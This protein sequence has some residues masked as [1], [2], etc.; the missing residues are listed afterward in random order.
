VADARSGAVTRLDPAVQAVSG[1]PVPVGER[2][3]GLDAGPNSLWV[4]LAGEDAVRRLTLPSGE[5]DGGPIAVGPEPSAV[6]VGAGAV[7]VVHDG[8]GSV[9]RIE[10]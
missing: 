4:T 9:T 3:G 1:A 8:D 5:P 6:A 10:P 2:P 7:W